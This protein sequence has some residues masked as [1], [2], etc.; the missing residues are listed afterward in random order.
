MTEFKEEYINR[1]VAYFILNKYAQN[2]NQPRAMR[3]AAKLLLT[4]PK[5]KVRKD[6]KGEWIEVLEVSP[7]RLC[8]CS[9]CG[10]SEWMTQ[11]FLFCPHCG[12]DMR[13]HSETATTDKGAVDE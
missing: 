10:K 8:E 13:E 11:P 9:N 6:I 5:S 1:D 7:E 2:D 12:A 3:R 4:F